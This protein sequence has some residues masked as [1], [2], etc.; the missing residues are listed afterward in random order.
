MVLNQDAHSRDDRLYDTMNNILLVVAA[1]LS[2]IP[3][4]DQDRGDHIPIV[5]LLFWI[6]PSTN[7]KCKMPR[8]K[9]NLSPLHSGTEVSTSLRAQSP[10]P[11]FQAYLLLWVSILQSLSYRRWRSFLATVIEIELRTTS[12]IAGARTPVVRTNRSDRL[13]V[14]KQSTLNNTYSCVFYLSGR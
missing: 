13:Y 7:W 3:R 6:H 10:F 1:A 4:L 2:P 8:F 11:L 14:L 5:S 12:Q 9:R